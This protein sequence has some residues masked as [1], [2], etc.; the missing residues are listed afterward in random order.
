MCFSFEPPP[1]MPPRNVPWVSTIVTAIVPTTRSV[2]LFFVIGLNWPCHRS[3]FASS[4]PPACE[5]TSVGSS[6]SAPTLGA[7]YVAMR[8]GFAPGSSLSFGGTVQSSLSGNGPASTA[9]AALAAGVVEAV[10]DAT[11]EV[12]SGFVE[13]GSGWDREQATTRSEAATRR[14]LTA[15]S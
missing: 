10:A 8:I 4:V 14:D 7:W 13:V 6:V 1:F 15:S 3:M 9:G 2:R 11:A 5:T 12:V